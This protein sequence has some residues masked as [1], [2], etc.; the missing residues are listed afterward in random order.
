[1]SSYPSYGKP[2]RSTLIQ[3][4]V[5]HWRG[6]P[7]EH[8]FSYPML[9]LQL[10][11]DEL[12]SHSFDSV[13]L[14]HN[15]WGVCSIWND[16]YL[17][18]VGSLRAKVEAV[19]EREGIKDVPH[20]ITL[21]TMPRYLGYVF[22]PVSF[23]I[24]FNSDEKVF[25]CVT[26]VHNTFGE[27]HVYPLVC[28]ASRLPVSW[29]FDKRFFVSPFF[30]SHGSYKLTLISEG[31]LFS[32]RVDLVRDGQKVFSATLNGQASPISKS[33]L[34]KALLRYPLTL[35]LTMP[36]IHMQAL[37]LIF[38]VKAVPQPKPVATEPYTI[39]SKQN[40]I[41][42]ARLAFLSALRRVRRV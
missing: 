37:K 33:N 27:C 19:L 15:R 3:G 18:G 25:A 6:T 7:R 5:W 12:A 16:D 34:I 21:V 8:S 41:H 42:R 14:R 36:R 32:V 2:L 10:D 26:Q 31:A 9:S 29:D 40:I 11:L 30:D 4:D 28:E 17:A 35:F 23:F 24:C 13:V 22:N 39:R 38:R 1:M 20:R